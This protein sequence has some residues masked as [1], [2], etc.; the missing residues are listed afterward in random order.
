MMST[1]FAQGAVKL[2][3][4]ANAFPGDLLTS[5]QLISTLN[6]FCDIKL[7]RKARAISRQL[8]IETRYFSRS[9]NKS[10]SLPQ[11]DAPTLC[12][13]AINTAGAANTD[14]LITHTTS[15]HTLLPSNAAWVAEKVGFE[16]PYMELRQACTGFTS[17]LQIAVPM[18]GHDKLIKKVSVC[19]SEIGSVY[20]NY[21]KDFVDVDQLINFMQMGDGASALVLGKDDG[22][23][24]QIISDCYVG[25]IGINCSP[26]LQIKGGGSQ[27]A[28]CK[29][30]LPYFEHHAIN[31]RQQGPLLFAKGVE[32]IT[33]RG[34]KLDDF[35]FILPHQANGHIDQLLSSFLKVDAER[36]VNTAKKWGNLGS[37]AI[38]ASLADLINT[39]KLQCGDKVAVLGAEATK[40]M[41]G[42]FVYTH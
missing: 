35:R 17:A 18:L 28:W 13:Q 24:R 1:H 29:K 21:E 42:G 41:Y 31:V 8:G 6:T 14:Y 16:K 5:S 34:Y 38:W 40:Y 2:I 30:N 10:F 27:Q 15:P 33:H 25:H 26:G 11:V 7:A 37:T 9:L 32:A 23:Q 22:S 39:G 12:Q 36:V 3:S 19:A 20:F 4:I